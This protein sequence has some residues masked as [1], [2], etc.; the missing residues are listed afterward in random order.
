MVMLSEDQVDLWYA[1]PE[2]CQEPSLLEEYQRLLDETETLERRRYRVEKKRREHVISKAMVRTALSHYAPIPPETWKFVR[3][4]TG[5][6]AID[7]DYLKLHLADLPSEALRLEF[8]LSHT[9]GMILCAVTWGAAVGVDVEDT[10]RAAEFLPLA[11]RFFNPAE[12]A[13][14]ENLPPDQLPL[15]F[16]R[17]WTLKEAYLKAKGVGLTTAL[18]AFSFHWPSRSLPELPSITLSSFDP[19]CLE[20]VGENAPRLVVFS[21]TAGGDPNHWQ[22]R[23]F[24]LEGR[25]QAALAAAWPPKRPLRITLRKAIPP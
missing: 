19:L 23:E 4:P 22:F 8:N 7:W 25:F 3:S 6:P 16:Y 18:D 15:A 13:L 5:K 9:E 12:I 17:F 11:R 24:L 21:P 1:R 20:E 10:V 14:L 2:E